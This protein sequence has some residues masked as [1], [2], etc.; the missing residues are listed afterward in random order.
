MQNK[1]SKFN[2]ERTCHKTPVPTESR[3]LDIESKVG[4]LSK[5]FLNNSKYGTA[6]LVRSQKLDECYGA[7]LYSVLSLAD[8]LKID[9]QS[10]LD[11]ILEEYKT[12]MQKNGSMARKDN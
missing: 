1:V 4:E 8:E 9:A 10:A 3:L 2:K 11:N 5:W 7:L 6:K 12:R